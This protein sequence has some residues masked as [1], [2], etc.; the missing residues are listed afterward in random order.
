[1]YSLCCG[2]VCLCM[3]NIFFTGWIT[4]RQMINIVPAGREP[5]LFI[6]QGSALTTRI[7]PVPDILVLKD[8]VQTE[9]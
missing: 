7:M 1:M 8:H 9:G 3:E 4:A 5:A 6:C 2:K